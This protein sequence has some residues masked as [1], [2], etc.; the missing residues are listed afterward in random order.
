MRCGGTSIALRRLAIWCLILTAVIIF[1]FFIKPKKDTYTEL[2][3][4]V[5][6]LER[7]IKIQHSLLNYPG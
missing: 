4:R 6:E 1:N 5:S 7:I 2:H 3:R